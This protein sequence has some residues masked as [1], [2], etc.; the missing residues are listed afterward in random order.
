MILVEIRDQEAELIPAKS[1]M[2]VLRA[3]RAGV[4]RQEV[5]RTNLLA[6]DLRNPFDDPIAHWMTQRVV[7]PLESGD[8]DEPNGRPPASLLEREK[9]FELLGEPPEV[10]QLCFG[11][12][13]RTVGQVGN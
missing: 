9:R 5:V 4:L 8:V 3:R 11:V 6:Q 10:H 2:Q 12:P 13:V 7:V 1:R